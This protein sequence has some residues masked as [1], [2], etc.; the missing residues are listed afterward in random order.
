MDAMSL[1]EFSTPPQERRKLPTLADM[2]T[3]EETGGAYASSAAPVAFGLDMRSRIFSSCDMPD[4]GNSFKSIASTE[5]VP[6][7]RPPRLSPL[8]DAPA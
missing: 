6:C 7:L 1:D 5:P 8:S 4:E 3:I 2:Q